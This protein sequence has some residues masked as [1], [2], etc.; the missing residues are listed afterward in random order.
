MNRRELITAT[1]SIASVAAATSALA[2]P[3]AAGGSTVIYVSPE[4]ADGNAGTKE[5][6]VQTIMEAAKRVNASSGSGAVTVILTEGIHSLSAETQFKPARQ[7]TKTARL[8]IRAEVLPDDAEWH[9]GRMPTIVP[10]MVLKPSWNGN[11]IPNGKT[12]NGIN[13]ETSFVTIQGLKFLGVPVVETPRTGEVNRIYPIG[14]FGATL[15][16]LEIAQCVFGGDRI[17]APNHCPI[18]ANGTGLNVHHCIF[19]NTKLT[20]VYWTYGSTGHSMHHCLMYG[21][22]EGGPWTAMISNDFDY[23]NNIIAESLNAWVQQPL[24]TVDPDAGRGARPP[25]AAGAAAATA[26]APPPAPRP[27]PVLKPTDGKYRIVNSLFAHNKR[28]AVSGTGSNLGFRDIDS[29][30]LQLVN[31]TV[32]D[33]PVLLVMDQFSRNYL[34]P[35][36]G[37]AAAALG[38][39]LFTKP[40]A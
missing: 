17:T 36:P 18:I 6:P 3:A 29:D 32:T 19:I 24:G 1:L 7:F 8:T 25:A 5:S 13:I 31:S 35:A 26:G 40:R 30:F 33:E 10:T 11:P 12:S 2:Q 39:G 23:H 38:A 21:V 27:R 28:M 4:G 14:R 9:S 22:Y 34:H 20:A 15:D 37:T 16:D